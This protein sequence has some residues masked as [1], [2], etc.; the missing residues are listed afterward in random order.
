MQVM[1]DKHTDAERYKLQRF[2]M[3]LTVRQPAFS[4]KYTVSQK[5][6]MAPFHFS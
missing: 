1:C 4:P 3:R 6:Y 5:K 2:I